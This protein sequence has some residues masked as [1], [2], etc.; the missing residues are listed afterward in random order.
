MNRVEDNQIIELYFARNEQAITETEDKYGQY[1]HTVANNILMNMADAQE[2]VNDTW[3]RAWHTIPP[4]RPSFFKQF[5]GKITRNLS[6]DRYRADTARKRGGGEVPAVLEELSECIGGGEDPAD[7]AEMQLLQSV[8]NQFVGSLP[9]REQGIFL[10]RYFYAE[11][12]S[13]IAERYRM[14]EANVRLVLSR[15]RQKLRHV[16]EKEDFCV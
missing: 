10:R 2:C 13:E 3:L 8:I 6:V 15:T 12:M 14:K 5:L 1:C 16:L 4:Q 9:Q 11:A 7:A